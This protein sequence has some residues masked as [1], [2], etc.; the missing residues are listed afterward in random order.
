MVSNQPWKIGFDQPVV[1]ERLH[2]IKDRIGNCVA[3]ATANFQA[4][5][6]ILLQESIRASDT[7]GGLLLQQLGLSAAPILRVHT[8]RGGFTK[9]RGPRTLVDVIRAIGGHNG[10]VSALSCTANCSAGP[11]PYLR[12]TITSLRLLHVIDFHTLL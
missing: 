4:I 5:F 3:M 11:Y 1:A 2:L 10:T 7:R 12:R 8:G 6:V 9:F